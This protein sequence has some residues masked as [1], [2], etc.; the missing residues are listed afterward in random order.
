MQHT[1]EE[2]DELYAAVIAV[3]QAARAS[4]D[5][6]LKER[7]QPMTAKKNAKKR[8]QPKR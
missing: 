3:N 6:V 7:F 4:R 8:Q 2:A 5:A 1:R